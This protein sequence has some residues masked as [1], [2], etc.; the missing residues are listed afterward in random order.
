VPSWSRHQRCLRCS[1]AQRNAAAHAAVQPHSALSAVAARASCCACCSSLDCAAL[2][3]LTFQRILSAC[4][5]TKS[6]R[7][8][9][10]AAMQLR[11]RGCRGLYRGVVT[12]P[13]HRA[14]E[15]FV[16]LG[17][18]LTGGC[19]SNNEWTPHGWLQGWRAQLPHSTASSDLTGN[20]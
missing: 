7:T 8:P 19:C 5:A 11:R 20:V 15:Q 17:A 3:L 12:R 14:P 16:A 9:Q 6:L 4:A 13:D 2:C 18:Q 1:G 10:T